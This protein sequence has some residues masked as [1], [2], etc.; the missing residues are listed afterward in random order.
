MAALPAQQHWLAKFQGAQAA[1]VSDV[2]VD[3]TGNVYVTGDLSATTT[4]S[5]AGATLATLPTA[6]GP[7]V[8]VAKFAPDGALLWAVHGGGPSVDVGLKLALAP[9]GVAVTGFFTG[10]ADLFGVNVQAQ[11]GSSDL[12]VAML[13][14]ADGQALWVRT[15][16]GPDHTE[17]PGG[18]AITPTGEVV[19]AGKFKGSATFGAV[20][21]Q[22][23]TDPGNGLPSFNPFLAAWSADGTFQWA[24]QGTGKKD[25]SATDIVAAPDGNLYVAGQFSDTLT[26]DVMHPATVQNGIFLLKTDAQ[27]QEQWF[28]T[29]AG[30]AYNRVSDLHWS[31][32]GNLLMAGDVGGT[33]QWS[34]GSA[35][36]SLVSTSP[37]AYFILRATPDGALAQHKIVGSTNAVHVAALAEQ[38]DSV[39]VL[40]DFTCSFTGLQDFYEASGL[41]RATGGPDLFVAKHAGNG[42]GLVRAQQ[43]AGTG[44]KT[45]GGLANTPDGLVFGGS[46]EQ[47]LY[48]PRGQ[49]NWGDPVGVCSF[50]VPNAGQTYCDDPYYGNF[51]WASG[52]TIASGFLTKGFVEGRSPYDFWDR[53]GSAACD[54]PDLDQ[55]V[56]ISLLQDGPPA[57]DTILVCPEAKLWS[58]APFARGDG[59]YCPVN[60]PTVGPFLS[61]HWSNGT[62][63]PSTS[64][65]AEGWLSFR[66]NSTNGCWSWADSV[67]VEFKPDPSLSVS[68][69]S[70]TWDHVN[71]PVETTVALC[72]PT[73]FWLDQDMPDAEV[74]WEAGGQ[75]FPGDTILIDAPG[76]YTLHVDI[77][78]ACSGGAVLYV[79]MVEPLNITGVHSQLMA[80]TVWTC[81]ALCVTGSFSNS[82][83]VDGVETELPPGYLVTFQSTQGCAQS[84]TTD[85][86]DDLPWG[87][88]VNGS[89]WYTVTS[90]VVVQ[91][92]DCGTGSFSFTF[93]ADVYVVVGTIPELQLPVTEVGR[94]LGDTVAVPFTCTNCDTIYWSSPLVWM[95]PGMDTVMVPMDGTFIATPV[96]YVGPFPCVASPSVLVVTTPTPPVLFSDPPGAQ[97]CPN[98]SIRLYTD[99]Q[100]NAYTWTG[101]GMANLPNAASIWVTEP[102]DYYLSV[103]LYPGCNTS[104]GPITVSFSASPLITAQPAGV[105]CAGQ[106]VV[107]EVTGAPDI[108]LQWQPP[109]SGTGPAQ[110]VDEPGIYTCVVQSCGTVWVLSVEVVASGVSADLGADTFTMCAGQSLILTAPPGGSYLWLPP[111]ETGQDYT[112]TAPGSYELIV[113]DLYGCTASSGPI[114]VL[115]D[116]IR[117]PATLIGDSV[118]QGQQAVVTA[119][120]S[121]L[122]RWFA[123]P[124]TTELLAEGAQYAFLPEATDTLYVV[125]SEA[126][127]VLGPLP[128]AVFVQ[129]RPPA[130]VVFG[131]TI[132]CSGDTLLF[133]AEGPPGSTFVWQTPMGT[134]EGAVYGP[135]TAGPEQSGSY[136]C[137]IILNGCAGDT[138]AWPMVVTGCDPILPDWEL[139]NVITPNGDGVNDRFRLD[140]PDL[141][142]A[143]L[144]IFNRWGQRVAVV[145]GAGATWDGRSSLSGQLLPE[146]VYFYTLEAVT[147]SGGHIG[148]NG[149]IQ[150]LR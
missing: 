86:N 12:F 50:L 36:T 28:R 20:T 75:T 143:E 57:P 85:A 66:V 101:P 42:L 117:T 122:V 128:V 96:S 6:G 121:G 92:A 97:G 17:T 11:G 132:H 21:L 89:G 61:Q 116:P 100:G 78:G 33:T 55:G 77:P 23:A 62:G 59:D 120:G 45:G 27:G 79:E 134:S 104:N 99:A 147:R 127:C 69:S 1:H 105:V 73:A 109:L 111:G 60:A 16:G 130:P 115:P 112:V 7:D 91:N 145:Q 83:L 48:M 82:W 8:L 74:F 22:S 108:Q 34:D 139:P 68:N 118:C 18:I 113:T 63:L 52:T 70:G 4:V 126:G 37:N 26:F 114:I 43:F 58:V 124:D 125:Q 29:M 65:G 54:R 98:D 13:D 9:G 84:G 133:A 131:D 88:A 94:C 39:V 76:M 87:I 30:A 137:F 107:L 148:R 102:G 49:A 38:A 93:T 146:G 41:F 67:Y 14:P 47:T 149:H 95:N 129:D 35:S 135:V 15:A 32:V 110:T 31:A 44:A 25:C 2:A 72:E 140:I 141:A 119:T 144:Q 56:Y 81:S 53:G 150:V 51:A 46:F 123:T 40:G 71:L 80:D 64:V 24:K 5:K 138:V 142:W 19:V 10:T 90:D 103:S 3:A 106:T 136:S